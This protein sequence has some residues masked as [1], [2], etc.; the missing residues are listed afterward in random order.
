MRIFSETLTAARGLFSPA[1]LTSTTGEKRT[2][3][4][5]RRLTSELP[6]AL[7]VILTGV[8]AGVGGTL[9]T[10]LLHAVQHVAFGYTENHFLQGVQQAGPLRRVV[11]VGVGGAIAGFG[12]WAHRSYLRRRAPE[13]NISVTHALTVAEPRLPVAATTIDAVL[14]IVAVGAGGSM[15]REGAPRQVGA[16]LGTALSRALHLDLS[17]RRILLAAGAGAGL[18]AVYNV[19]L[20]GAAFTLEVLLR[21]LSPRA[22]L[23]ALVT[24]GVAAVTAWPV[25][26]TQ[27]TYALPR[28]ATTAGAL[29]VVT[30][31]APLLGALAAPLGSAFRLLMTYARASAPS[32]WRAAV[33]IPLTFTA[34]GAAAIALPE[35]LGN[36]KG[37]AQLDLIGPATL[38][39]VAALTLLKPLA[40]AACLRSGAIGGLL[41]PAF[42]TGAT[43]G[44]LLAKLG[45]TI[46]APS[47]TVNFSLVGAA[48]V[49][50]VAQR[51]P[52]TA[53]VLT[54]EFAHPPLT[55]LPA[56]VLAVAAA[57]L[58]IR[59]SRRLLKQLRERRGRA[60]RP[61]GQLT[62]RS[63]R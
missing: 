43:F 56:L 50:A 21:T 44:V 52:V 22:L 39:S 1:E 45:A 11:A 7:A 13:T 51:A 54:V 62:R 12:W 28:P 42:A 37:L 61:A 57:L 49:L 26:G 17:S 27:P 30:V 18:A 55:I 48:A 53:V 41:T 32:G 33:A 9:L 36:G 25:L 6:F 38:G 2:S 24:S 35:L 5:R 16:A 4:T 14:Q 8:V 10:L 19:P 15:G 46:W 34:L 29:L 20:G 60:P 23:T 59:W 58:S 3:S 47:M 31:I 63:A 40:T